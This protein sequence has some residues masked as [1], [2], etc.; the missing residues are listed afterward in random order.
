MLLPVLEE[1]S[2]RFNNAEE[3]VVVAIVEWMMGAVLIVVVSVMIVVELLLLVSVLATGTIDCSV[4]D[5]A[6]KLFSWGLEMVVKS[7]GD[8]EVLPCSSCCGSEDESPGGC[9][10]GDG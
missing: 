3:E 6:D 1:E 5:D 4:D 7:L 10:W 9:R 2:L 8:A